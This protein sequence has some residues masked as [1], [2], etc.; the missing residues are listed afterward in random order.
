MQ[1]I[2]EFLYNLYNSLEQRTDLVQIN[3][4]FSIFR[5]VVSS[6]VHY[7]VCMYLRVYHLLW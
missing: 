5:L 7:I 2:D 3:F 4:S 1:K 6:D